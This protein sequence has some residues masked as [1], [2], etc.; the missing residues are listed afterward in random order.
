MIKTRIYTENGKG[1]RVIITG[2]AGAPG[3]DPGPI[4]LGICNSVTTA[5]NYLLGGINAVTYLR[6]KT[7]RKSANGGKLDFSWKFK[8]EKDYFTFA[9]IDALLAG[10]SVVLASIEKHWPGHLE[11]WYNDKDTYWKEQLSGLFQPEEKKKLKNKVDKIRG[12]N[13]YSIE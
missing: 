7:T 5:V 1:L 8:K 10:F 4:E 9:K 2:H 11:I 13:I 12:L 6:P 3:K